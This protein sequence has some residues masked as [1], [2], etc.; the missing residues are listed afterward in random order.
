MADSYQPRRRKV[1]RARERYEARQK[2]RGGPPHVELDSESLKQASA[3]AG[4]ISLPLR[5]AWWHL[6][7]VPGLLSKVGAALGALALLYI[8]LHVFQGRTFPNVWAFGVYLGD[9]TVDEAEAALQTAWNQDIQIA[10]VDGDRRWTA[11]PGELG[12]SLDARPIAEAARGVGLAGMPFGWYLDPNV[13]MNTALAQEFVLALSDEADIHP[14]NAGYK[15]EGD[16]VAGV[17]GYD[18]RRLNVVATM[19]KLSQDVV[20]IIKDRELA[21]VMETLPPDVYDP[22]LYLEEARELVNNPF[23]MI[24]YDPF[25]DEYLSW[26]TTADVFVSWLQAGRD[27]LTLREEAFAPFLDAQNASLD[28]EAKPR[29]LDHNETIDKLREAIAGHEERVNLRIRYRPT[30]YEI[31]YGDRAYSI[32]RQT[33]IPFFLVE[34]ANA[35]RDLNTLS[36][37]DVINLPSRD[38]TLPLDPVP[39]KRIIVD[40]STQSLVAYENGQQVFNWLISSGMSSAPTSPGVF[41]VLSHDDVALGSS[42]TLCNSQGCGQWEMYWFMG[43]YEVVP[44]LMNGFHGAVLLPNGAYLGGGNVGAPY[45]FGCIMSLDSNAKL[46]YDWAEEGTIVEIISSEFSPQSDLARQVVALENT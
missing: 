44:G 35:G 33:G 22:D 40:L 2:R 46:L 27:G 3:W 19:D 41:Q 24:G 45:T 10:L 29:Y 42:Y 9:M 37:G 11:S 26:K 32:A 15:L 1:S 25:T 21:L 38:V 4:R 31:A 30:Q 28:G 34:E 8:L 7:R 16:E 6:S 14:A 13:Q 12:L 5:D 39:N 43:I 23:Q 18:G 36:P 20:E 17:A